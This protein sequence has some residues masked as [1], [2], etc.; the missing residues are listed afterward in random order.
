MGTSYITVFSYSSF[1]EIQ[2]AWNEKELLSYIVQ[3][4][5]DCT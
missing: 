2:I 1:H 5:L 4:N 3:Q